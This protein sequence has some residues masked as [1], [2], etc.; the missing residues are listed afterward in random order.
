MGA[1]ASA[2]PRGRAAARADVCLL[3]EGTYPLVRGGVAGWVHQI[4]RGLPEL[5]FA[6]VFIGGRRADYG[7]SKYDVPPNVVHFE[8]HFLE[9][10]FDGYE[11]RR[12]RVPGA[13]LA[14]VEAL[15][16]YLRQASAEG[17]GA[18]GSDGTKLDERAVDAVLASLERSGGLGLEH[19]LFGEESWD[20][21]KCRHLADSRPASFVDYFWTLRFIHGPLFQLARL[22]DGIPDAR[23]YHTISTGYAGLLGVFLEHRRRRPLILSEHGIYTKERRIDLNQAEWL[24]PVGARRSAE[25]GQGAAVL[26]ELWIRSFESLGRLVYRSARPII[27]LYEGNRARQQREG[28]APER[29][30]IIVNGIDLSRFERA[31]A[32]RRL[33]T[34]HVVG[35]IGRV[36]PIKDIKTFIRAIGVLVQHL[37]DAVGCIVGGSDEGASYEQECRDLAQSLGLA[38]QIRF[39]G[40]R[41]VV[42]VFPELGLLMLTSISE[43][44]PLCLLE[45]FASGVPCVAT[46]VGSCR[47]LIEGQGEAD[48]ALGRAGRVA[49]FADHEGLGQAA[50]ELLRDPEAW[51][52]CAEAAHARAHRYYAEQTMLEAYR[53]VYREAMYRE[54]MEAPW[55][56]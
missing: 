22:A 41:D 52:A 34:P 47:V 48:R 3:L 38:E 10:A 28:A 16:E 6:L 13:A 29:T 26:R 18:A 4:I 17:H 15:H 23:A 46:D 1:A 32:R 51:R 31:R 49:A 12:Q 50:L 21:I 44:Q 54:A 11:P 27:S 19:F 14:E 2:V 24:E 20:L 8:R 55:P 7:E 45:A 9:D 43:G 42:E 40:H 37:P 30:R 5:T 39:L 36:V 56:A 25:R 33:P 53:G 35:L